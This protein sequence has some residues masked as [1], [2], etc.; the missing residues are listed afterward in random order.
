MIAL[1]MNTDLLILFQNFRW[2][3]FPLCYSVLIFIGFTGWWW[4]LSRILIPRKWEPLACFLYHLIRFLQP[5]FAFSLFYFISGSSWFNIV[6]KQGK[7][8]PTGLV[9]PSFPL[10]TLLFIFILAVLYT[11]VFHLQIDKVLSSILN[12]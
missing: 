3:Y 6:F 8:I 1:E 12:L 2:R 4:F 5:L 9:I 10:N 11:P 7:S